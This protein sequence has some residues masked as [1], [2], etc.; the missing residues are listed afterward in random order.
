MAPKTDA[1]QDVAG[2]DDPTGK[3]LEL[4]QSPELMDP[5]QVQRDIAERI[6]NSDPDSIEA[7][8]ALGDATTEDARDIVGRPFK[9]VG[10]LNW[11]RSSFTDAGGPGVFVAVPLH[12]LDTDTDGVVTVGG[13]NVCAQL[14]VMHTKG[15]VPSD[16]AMQFITKRSS[17]GYDVLWLTNAKVEEKF[18]DS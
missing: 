15:F 12:F 10:E 8:L 2:F 13:A 9:V 1:K 18:Q 7:V 5:A 6:L 3:Y 17:R 14:Y 16:A 11:Y 4:V